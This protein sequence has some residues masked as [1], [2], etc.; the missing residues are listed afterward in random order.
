MARTGTHHCRCPRSCQE[1]SVPCQEVSI[2]CQEVSVPCACPVENICHSR[3]EAL[4]NT[5]MC[6]YTHPIP[7][8]CGCGCSCGCGCG[9]NGGGCHQETCCTELLAATEQQNNLLCE[10]LAAVSGLTAACLCRKREG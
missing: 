8:G 2:P 5:P 4:E 10:L 1:V 3:R 9:C 6:R 7:N